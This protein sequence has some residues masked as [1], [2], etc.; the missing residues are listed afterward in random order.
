MKFDKA[1]EKDYQFY[2]NQF[3]LEVSREE[4]RQFLRE[5][6]PLAMKTGLE[7]Y[8][9]QFFFETE[10]SVSETDLEVKVVDRGGV[11]LGVITDHFLDFPMLYSVSTKDA[12]KLLSH[13]WYSFYGGFDLARMTGYWEFPQRVEGSAVLYSDNSYEPISVTCLRTSIEGVFITNK[14]AGKGVYLDKLN[15]L[16]E[17][18]KVLKRLYFS[19]YHSLLPSAWVSKFEVEPY[20]EHSVINTQV[21]VRPFIEVVV[22]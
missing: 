20:T 6:N 13:I 18:S 16:H 17:L 8:L 9:R 4:Y 5:A 12:V 11:E 7:N 10:V 15:H 22:I 19:S 14:G 3:G 21:C 1:L 2:L